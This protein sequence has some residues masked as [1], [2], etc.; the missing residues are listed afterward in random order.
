MNRRRFLQA[1]PGLAALLP[2]TLAA[3]PKTV[4]APHLTLLTSRLAGYH[5]YAGEKLWSNITRGDEL[6]LFREPG[7]PHDRQAVALLWKGYKLGYIP[8]RDNT[9]IAQLLDRGMPLRCRISVR[10]ESPDP[11]NRIHFMV[12]ANM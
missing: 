11:W 2:V 3:R 10:R 9:V 8:R 12:T 1:L 4:L 7:N 5:Y 6:E